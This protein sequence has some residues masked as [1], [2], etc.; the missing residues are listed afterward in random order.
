MKEL[1]VR[2]NWSTILKTFC[3]QCPD[4]EKFNTM[5]HNL[6]KENAHTE[7]ES[8]SKE[9]CSDSICSKKIEVKGTSY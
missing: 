9:S 7:L 2:I 5:N 8:S 1:V 6:L 4:N 3:S